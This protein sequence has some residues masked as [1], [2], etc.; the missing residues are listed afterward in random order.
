M[1][2]LKYFH[3]VSYQPDEW[4]LRNTRYYHF[5]R[6]DIFDRRDKRFCLSVDEEYRVVIRISYERCYFV[7][8]ICSYRS[9][10][11]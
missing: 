5:Y 2:C 6:E 4:L 9:I 3:F 11:R 1:E 10:R 8:R 7:V